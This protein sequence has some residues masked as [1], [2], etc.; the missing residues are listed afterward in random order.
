M[1]PCGQTEIA[2]LQCS[3]GSLCGDV[4]WN[5]AHVLHSKYRRVRPSSRE[6]LL[7][8]SSKEYLLRSTV[9][10]GSVAIAHDT[11]VRL[12]T[13]TIS[14]SHRAPHGDTTLVLSEQ[15]RPQRYAHVEHACRPAPSR[16][17]IREIMLCCI[18]SVLEE[19]LLG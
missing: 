2:T 17:T 19:C 16:H 12:S 9:V 14:Y 11:S 10:E 18:R 6:Y 13:D 8:F 4:I 15:T 3:C 1:Q 5:T 7:L